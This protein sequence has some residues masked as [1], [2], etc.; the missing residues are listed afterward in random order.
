MPKRKTGYA[1]EAVALTSAIVNIADRLE[2]SQRALAS[3]IGLSE[4]TI[5]RMRKGT[6]VLER[7]IGKSFELAQLLL[8]IDDLLD[9]II[10][11]DRTAAKAWLVAENLALRGRPIDLIQS[12]QGLVEV[13]RYLRARSMT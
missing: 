8:S 3:I 13:N 7:D 11:G 10:A 6:F 9:E 5:S 4:P 2:I 1:S 12:V